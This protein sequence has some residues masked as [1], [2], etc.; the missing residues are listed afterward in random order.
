[1]Y[2]IVHARYQKEIGWYPKPLMTWKDK[3][4]IYRCHSRDMFE[5][6]QQEL[7]SDRESEEI[8][9]ILDELAFYDTPDKDTF[10]LISSSASEICGPLTLDQ[11]AEFLVIGRTMDGCIG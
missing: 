7:S 1:M 11:K 10:E 3:I 6:L 5:R 4:C 2:I 9:E 8:G